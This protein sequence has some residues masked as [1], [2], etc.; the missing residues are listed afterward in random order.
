MSTRGECLALEVRRSFTSGDV[1]D[2][3]REL[4]LIRQAPQHVR[5]DNGPEFIAN[6][7]RS[8]LESARG[9][10]VVH[11]AGVAVGERLRRELPRATAR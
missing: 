2:V 4:V 6:A 9:G 3:L 10:D 1:I 5:S 7:I 8:W 11:R